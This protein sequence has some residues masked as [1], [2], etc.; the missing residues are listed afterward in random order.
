M[1]SICFTVPGKPFGKQRPRVTRN[2]HAYT[3]KETVSYENLVRMSFVE[4]Y[5][6]FIPTGS[7]VTLAVTAVFPIPQSWPKKKVKAALAGYI[8][9]GKPDID[10][11]LKIIQDAL[12]G[13]AYKDDA[14]IWNATITK[15]YAERPGVQVYLEYIEETG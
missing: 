14:Q 8:C 10:N 9:P 4:K 7:P 5:P 12:N 2:G 1:A 6:E 3:P 15:S 11:V 13:I